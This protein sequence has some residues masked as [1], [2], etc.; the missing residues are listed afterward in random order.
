MLDFSFSPALTIANIIS[1]NFIKPKIV[2]S[3]PLQKLSTYCIP[4]TAEAITRIT[5][6][7][8]IK[9]LT[10]GRLQL[11]DMHKGK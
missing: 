5:N 3:V 7:H 6:T 9:F 1:Q 11:T 2:L 4:S 8:M 10:P